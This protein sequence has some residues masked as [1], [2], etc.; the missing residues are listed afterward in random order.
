MSVP[1]VFP[2]H[3]IFPSPRRLL[4]QG[5]LQTCHGIARRIVSEDRLEEL[6]LRR[7]GIF[8]VRRRLRREPYCL[9]GRDHG[10]PQALGHPLC[11]RFH[12]A[13]SA[14]DPKQVEACA[15]KAPCQAPRTPLHK[16]QD[17]RKIMISGA[18]PALTEPRYMP[19]VLSSRAILPSASTATRP[20][21]PPAFPRRS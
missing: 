12:T 5:R 14:T 17:Y 15:S 2:Y 13:Y 6:D 8:N 1:L 9:T 20:P 18:S 7:R 10:I 21:S 16:T 11:H 3:R 19:G 4:C